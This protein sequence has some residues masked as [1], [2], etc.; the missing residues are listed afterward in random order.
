MASQML[1]NGAD[2]RFIQV[3]LEHADIKT[4]QVYTRVS[5]RAL[6]DIRRLRVRRGSGDRP[7]IGSISE[8]ASLRRYIY[9]PHSMRRR[10]ARAVM[11]Y[12]TEC[13][14]VRQKNRAECGSSRLGGL[15]AG[16]TRKV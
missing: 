11:I 15:H 14:N 4:T 5:I 13:Y 12:S 6:K 10:L 2:V 7:K 3:M 1:E 9:W 16:A 8:T